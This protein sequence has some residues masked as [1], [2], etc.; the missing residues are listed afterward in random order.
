LNRQF[1]TILKAYI[2]NV[3]FY[4]NK[5]F[6]DRF[7]AIVPDLYRGKVATDHEHAGHYSNDLDRKGA[8]E[9]IQGTV[10]YLK[11]KG[12]EKV[13]V[14]G[15]CMGGALAIASSVLVDGISAA[16]PFYGIPSSDLVDP[17]KAKSPLQLHFGTKDSIKDFSDTEAQDKLEKIL[18]E[19]NVDFEFFRYDG[20]DHAFA[21]ETAVG[22]Y[23]PEYA[24][25]AQQRTVQFFEKLLN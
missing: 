10:N 25:L 2:K 20:G 3:L 22:R 1:L 5:W 18:K 15:F 11:S 13:G 19:S 12:V 17:G 16:V 24:K 21:N 4:K 23:N 7:I 6:G 14:V 8:I 9:D